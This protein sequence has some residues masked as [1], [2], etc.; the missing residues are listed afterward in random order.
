MFFSLHLIRWQTILI[1]LTNDIHFD[2]LIELVS[3]SEVTLS[4]FVIKK[5]LNI[6][7]FMSSQRKKDQ[8]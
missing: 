7:V 2:H 3:A 5:L 1:C 8:M 6:L 4:P